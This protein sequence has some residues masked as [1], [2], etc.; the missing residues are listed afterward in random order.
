MGFLSLA[1]LLLEQPL[2]KRFASD[3]L[4]QA[5]MSLLHERIPKAS[6]VYSNTTEL[7]DIRSASSGQEIP[8][9][10]LHHVNTRTPEVQLLSNGRYHV[11]ISSVGGS[12]S[13]WNDLAITRWNEDSTRDHWG[14]F[15][16]V[17]DVSNGRYWS[18]AFQPCLVN[19]PSYEVI[20]SEGRA[21]FRRSDNNL[22]MHTEIVVS[23][24]DDIELRRT[25]IVNRSRHRRTIDFTSYA[26]VVLAPAAADAMHP[27][28]SKLFVETEILDAQHAILCSRR[29]RSV[30][31]KI[32]SMFHLMALHGA[33]LDSA[34]YETDRA[35]FIGRGNTLEA[36]AAMRVS[37][38]SDSQGSVLDPVVAIRYQITLE[39]EQ[40]VTLD[41]VTGVAENRELCIALIDKY[42]DKHLA[43]RVIELSWTHSQV[44]LRQLNISETDAQLYGRLANSVIYMNPL[45]RADASIL[46]RNHR[47]Q[48]G[49]WGYAISGDLPIVLL[50]INHQDHIELVRQLVQA[51]AYWRSKGLAVDLVIWNEDHATYR[52]ALQEQIMGMISSVIGTHA[53]ERPGGIFVRMAEQ[54]SPED[55][56]L[57]Q[58]VARVILNDHRG[59]LLEQLNRRDLVELRAPKLLPGKTVHQRGGYQSQTDSRLSQVP[60][61]LQNFNGL[62]GFSEDGREY[63]ITTREG[64]VTPAPWVNVLANPHFGS[65]ISE[66]GQAYTWAENAHEFRL[67]PWNNDPVCDSSGEAFYIRDEDTGEYWSPPPCPAVAAAIT[68]PGMALATV[69]SPMKNRAYLLS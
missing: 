7:A 25:R 36:P 2:Q 40:A 64:Q 23:P 47:G 69:Y 66:S 4:F 31:E 10:V 57:F 32:P 5:T 17:R 12:Y 34:S 51:H 43:D 49:L 6:A 65:V 14:T 20:F 19:S 38:L 52:Q 42:Q 55:K 16:Y 24:E 13:R 48:S 39:P 35:K 27:A 18:T 1:Y 63:V 61:K 37:R 8:L 44:V 22:D 56:T 67:T 15:C 59:S 9:R 29:P 54:I 11:M 58:A 68:S 30:D 26:E 46:S 41:V 45:L 33:S 3:P 62:G 21:E 28:F 53:T 60:G 50:Q